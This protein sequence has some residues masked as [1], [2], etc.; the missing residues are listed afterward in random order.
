MFK[1]TVRGT[2]QGVGFRPFIHRIAMSLGLKGYVKNTGDGSVEI[3]IDKKMELFLQLLRDHPPTVKIED[4]KIEKVD[5]PIPD[6]FLILPSGGK[7]ALSLPPP[8]MAVCD[9]CLKEVFDKRDRRYLYPFTSCTDC[10]ARFSIV[11]ILP[12]D[13]ENTSLRDFPMCEECRNE[14]ENVH[15]RRY[16]AQT[17]ACSKCGPRYRFVGRKDGGIREAAEAIERGEIIAIKGIGGYH[18]ACLTDDDVVKRLRNILGRP[19]Q[20]FAVMARDID[21]VR[22]VAVVDDVEKE[23]LMSVE[24]PIVIL[25]KRGMNSLNEVAPG[26]DTVGMMLPYAPIHHLLFSNMKSDFMVMTS[27]NLPGEPMYIDE[28]VFKLGLDG[29]LTHNLKIV[30]RVDDSVV[31]FCG[32][33]RMLIR[34]SRGFVPQPIDLRIGV[35]A[36]AVGAELYNSIAILKE[37]KAVLSQY[38]G[39]TYNFKTYNEFFK[40]T[41]DFFLKFL[42]VDDIDYV[43]SD[44]HP[45]FNTTIFAERI[46]KR[47]SARHIKVQHHFAHAMSVMAEKNLSRAVAIAVDGVG[48]G[49]DGNVWGGEVLYIDTEK[50]EFRRVGRLESFELIGGDAAIIRPTRI[51]VS[52]LS[53]NPDLLKY[54]HEDVSTLIELLPHAVKTTSAG[55]FLD[56]ASAMLEVCFE[57]TYEGEPAMKLEAIAKES[58]TEAE[59]EIRGSREISIFESPFTPE[60]KVGSVEVLKLKDFFVECTKRYLSGE[61]RSE[62]AYEVL[63]YLSSGLAEI[64]HPVSREMDC[65]VIVCGGVA[66]NSFFTKILKKRLSSKLL[67]PT[68]FPAGDNGISL[69]QLYSLK[70]LEGE[71]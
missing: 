54:Y 11:E 34:R 5:L 51:L 16:Y 25:R 15:D 58:G 56:A 20:P 48:Y 53:D 39:N 24:R 21:S 45:L 59:L 31:K 3:V 4:L 29:Y 9:K 71:E 7:S 28:S 36:L 41:V 65:P 26:L 35:N 61:S 62:I 1:I 14:Y 43:V 17:I 30:N 37:N 18:I 50:K 49:M 66:Y 38:I 12:F 69:G 22:R 10:G 33:S 40:K 19:Q 23:E 8:D 67:I 13:R 68:N 60:G 42:R 46:A 64:A 32:G 44:M 6:G 52:L 55:R 63:S 2:V 27:A 57:R 70:I 47:L